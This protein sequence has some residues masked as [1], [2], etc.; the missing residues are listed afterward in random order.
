MGNLFFPQLST[1][2]LAQYP[3]RKATVARTIRNILPDGSL[4]LYPD[5]SASLMAWQFSYTNLP[6][7]DW[8]SLQNHFSVCSGPVHAFTFIDPTEN[9]FVSS[10]DP[11]G[12]PWQ[13][14][15]LITFTPNAADPNGGTAAFTVTNTG[16]TPQEITQALT[17]PSGYQYCFS[18]Y[19]ISVQPGMLS[20]LRRGSV[21]EEIGQTPIGPSWSRFVSSGR[22]SDS[23]TSF[24]AGVSLAPG[25][26]VTIFGPQLEPQISPSGYRPTTQRGGVYAN[27]HWTEERLTVA[28]EAPD[29][30]STSFMIEAAIPA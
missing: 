13:H 11:S 25:Q 24:T 23:G 21:Q 12:A 4:V 19:A 20:L 17:I 26:Q 15:P 18:L 7:N 30:F 1:G 5:S 27:A 8:V 6:S 3:I 29:L 14:S 16:Q 2:A 9:M 28:A 22:L 10:S